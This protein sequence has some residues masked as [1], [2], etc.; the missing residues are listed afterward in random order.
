ME[1]QVQTVGPAIWT[2]PIA[3]ILG[4]PSEKLYAAEGRRPTRG[5]IPLLAF[6]SPL[7]KWK[8][9]IGML[10]GVEWELRR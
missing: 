7:S 3:C 1:R 9:R 8:L 10:S 4:S 6:R 5:Q 2:F